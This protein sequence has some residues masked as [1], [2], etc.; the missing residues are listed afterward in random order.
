M[1]SCG[2]KTHSIYEFIYL[3]IFC[4][5]LILLVI[6]EVFLDRH[7]FEVWK[8]LLPLYH[9]IIWTFLLLHMN[10]QSGREWLHDEGR[11]EVRL[12]HWAIFKLGWAQAKSHDHVLWRQLW[13]FSLLSWFHFSF[14][15]ISSKNIFNVFKSSFSVAILK[16]VKSAP[17]QS[18]VKEAGHTWDLSL[19]GCTLPW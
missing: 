1:C 15:D 7:L 5:C 6:C 4:P 11:G 2:S 9:K 3:F 12:A 17:H 19:S 16:W 8:I 18:T 10:L 14:L 13:D